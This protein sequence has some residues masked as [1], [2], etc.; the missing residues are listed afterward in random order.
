MNFKA[1]TSELKVFE[2]SAETVDEALEFILNYEKENKTNLRVFEKETG[3]RIVGGKLIRL[4][5]F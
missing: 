5:K 3:K 4:V 2:F 1:R